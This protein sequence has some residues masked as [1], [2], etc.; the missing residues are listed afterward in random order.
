MWSSAL[1]VW[2]GPNNCAC[3]VCLVWLGQL[4]GAVIRKHGAAAEAG[5]DE[6]SAS[7]FPGAADMVTRVC[8]YIAVPIPLTGCDV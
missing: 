8:R 5:R 1:S 6:Q 4:A 3:L 7:Q 2:H